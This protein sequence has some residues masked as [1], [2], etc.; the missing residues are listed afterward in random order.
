MPPHGFNNNKVDK[1][2]GSTGVIPTYNEGQ[3]DFPSLF[4]HVVNLITSN[5]YC[6]PR[7]KVIS[8]LFTGCGNGKTEKIRVCTS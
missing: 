2:K 6:F 5:T 4:D 1:F 3:S 7:H 8:V